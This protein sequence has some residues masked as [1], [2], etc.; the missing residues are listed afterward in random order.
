MQHHIQHVSFLSSA[1][2]AALNSACAFA[3]SQ[4]NFQWIKIKKQKKDYQTTRWCQRRSKR[5]KESTRLL[6]MCKHV[7]PVDKQR[8]GRTIQNKQSR[9]VHVQKR[10]AGR[11]LVSTSSVK[12][13]QESTRCSVRASTLNRFIN[14]DTAQQKQG[15]RAPVRQPVSFK[16]TK[17]QE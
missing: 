10:S 11:A 1:A 13:I 4:S 9:V 14:K 3:L 2:W 12:K 7:E 15:S 5:I 16:T 6:S 8:Q 17:I